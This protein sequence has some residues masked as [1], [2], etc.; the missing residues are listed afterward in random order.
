MPTG[1]EKFI[2]AEKVAY[3]GIDDVGPAA[4]DWPQLNFIIYHSATKQVIPDRDAVEQFKNDGQIDWV[5]DLARIPGQFGVDNV[6]AELGAVFAATCSAHPLLCAGILGSLVKEMGADHVCW[7][8]DSVWFGS[9]QW[10]IEALRRFEIP[11]DIQKRFG[12]SPLGPADGKVKNL[13][14]GENSALLY[15]IDPKAYSS[16]ADKKE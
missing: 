6:Y 11:E 1:Y 12:F 15:G 10:Q 13:I 14:F 2:P 16:G 8:T 9:P 7:G 4:R 3:A 5:T